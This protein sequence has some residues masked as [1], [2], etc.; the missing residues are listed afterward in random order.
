M[1]GLKSQRESKLT[2]QSDYLWSSHSGDDRINPSTHLVV[3]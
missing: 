1:Q 2:Y 3:N